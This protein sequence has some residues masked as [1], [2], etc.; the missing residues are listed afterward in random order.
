[1]EYKPIP[2][3]IENFEKM[4]TSGY[5]YVDKTWFIKELIDKKGEINLFTRPRRFGKSLCLSMVRHFFEKHEK[6]EKGWAH[7]FE[8][9]KIM[10]AGEQYT[11]EMNKYPVIMLT[12]KNI[13]RNTYEQSNVQMRYEFIREFRRHRYLLNSE[14]LDSDQK[15]SYIEIL[16][17]EP[18]N[19][20]I[21]NSIAFLSECLMRHYGEKVIILIDEYDVPLERSYFFGYYD[22]MINDI[23]LLFNSALKT[24]EALA[25]AVIT[26]CLRVSKESIFTGF[27]NPK[28]ISITSGMYG[29]YFGFTDD[30][31]AGAFDFYKLGHKLDE[32]RQWYNG[33]VF[34][35]TNVYNPWSILNFIQDSDENEVWYPRPYWANTSSNYIIRDLVDIADGDARNEIEALIRG[36]SITKPIHE[37]VVYSEINQD[38][39]NLWNFLYFTGYLKKTGESYSNT[40]IYYDL[41]IPN[42]EV[43]TIYVRKISEWF[44]DKV[45]AADMDTMYAAI[46]ASDAEK[47]EAELSALPLFGFGHELITLLFHSPGL[48][49]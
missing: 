23:R 16:N 24:N 28:I 20:K 44:K 21:I 30:E 12:L 42:I 3:G 31:V 10:S 33:Y 17:D 9:L 29:E 4:I 13:E 19:S 47:F 5:Y 32:A 15:N 6:N 39:N 36:E 11:S 18:D 43:T 38:I 49:P 22:E 2:I 8:G 26:G 27:N 7:L 40:Q 41:R 34:G 37:D 45:K 46:L 25:F 48:S 1:M 35:N 14:V